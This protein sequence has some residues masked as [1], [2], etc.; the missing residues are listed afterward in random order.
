M[1]EM[2]AMAVSAHE[3]VTMATEQMSDAI[4]AA[5]EAIDAYVDTVTHVASEQEASDDPNTQLVKRMRQF[6]GRARDMTKIVEDQ[7]LTHLNFCTDRL[8]SVK[9]AEEGTFI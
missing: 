3:R 6:E 2:E 8:F 7:V 1:E 9:S 4:Y 5:L